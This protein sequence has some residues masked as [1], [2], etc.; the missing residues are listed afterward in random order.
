MEEDFLEVKNKKRRQGRNFA[1]TRMCI[2]FEKN[3]RCRNG[4]DCAYAHSSDEIVVPPC[5]YGQLCKFKDRCKFS[6][7][8]SVENKL[9]QPAFSD[10]D[11]PSFVIQDG[12]SHADEQVGSSFRDVCCSSGARKQ[13]VLDSSQL[14][15]VVDEIK[16]TAADDETNLFDLCFQ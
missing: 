7:P 9:E 10:K 12:K 16:K 8:E 2:Y 4:N 1:K 6:H 14:F 5:H 3:G 15:D 11:F 13:F